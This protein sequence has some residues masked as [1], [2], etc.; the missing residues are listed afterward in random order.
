[1][2]RRGR[3]KGERVRD[4]ERKERNKRKNL[5]N[6]L[7]GTERHKFS[8]YSQKAQDTVFYT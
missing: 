1:M 2:K 6:T 5:G 4:R 8:F 3:E 7:S